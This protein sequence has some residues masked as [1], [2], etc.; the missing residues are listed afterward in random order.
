MISSICAIALRGDNI[1]LT[2]IEGSY[3]LIRAGKTDDLRLYMVRGQVF[4]QHT[5]DGAVQHTDP[6]AIQGLRL[7]CDVNIRIMPDK[8]IGFIAHGAFR[9]GNY[10]GSL[11]PPGKPRQ[12]IDLAIQE[13]PIQIRK[14]AVH[15]FILPAR[16]FRKFAVVFISV[17]GL[18]RAFLRTLLKDLVFV[19]PNAD[20]LGLRVSKG[21]GWQQ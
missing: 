1:H 8:I 7:R 17:A 13:Q 16:V 18:D 4:L 2:G 11:L 21:C 20:G 5:D 15:V 9:I 12:Q 19:I 3:Q 10:L 14:I 6:A